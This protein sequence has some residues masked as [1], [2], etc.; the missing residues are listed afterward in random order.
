MFHSHH[1]TAIH[2]MIDPRYLVSIH[3]I[4]YMLYFHSHTF[5]IFCKY[6]KSIL[7]E[8]SQLW[9]DFL[10]SRSVTRNTSIPR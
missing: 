1:F 3:R 7:A 9:T 4:E 6:F 2:T 10:E 5:F 8:Q